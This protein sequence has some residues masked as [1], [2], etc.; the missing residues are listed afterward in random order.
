MD[1]LSNNDKKIWN[2]VSNANNQ[3]EEEIKEKD[4]LSFLLAEK[5]KADSIIILNQ[6]VII[7]EKDNKNIELQK[8]NNILTKENTGLK[9][10]NQFL[11][12]L[13]WGL[14]L[15][16]FIQTIYIITK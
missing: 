1:I 9:N 2:I 6:K 12:Y 4:S 8:N 14:S 10:K 13:T 5:N 7:K 15:T 3:M 16:T 11:S